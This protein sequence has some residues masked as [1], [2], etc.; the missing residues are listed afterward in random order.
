MV[1]KV[2][3]KDIAEKVG[4][5]IALVSYV[6]NNKKEG[7]IGKDVAEKIRLTAK[8][9]N[10]RPNLIAK[11]LKS[12]R[13]HTIGLIV[14]DIANPFSANLARI[15]ED[16]AE[17]RGYIVIFGSSDEQA[18]KSEKLID[19]FL[20]RQ[21]DGF[22]IAPAAHS[23][24]Q[25]ED[26]LKKEVPLVLIDRYFPALKVSY[27]GIDNY[28]ASLEGVTHLINTGC[29]RIGIITFKTSL[30][31]LKDRK[32]GY[33]AALKKGGIAVSNNWIQE[34]PIEI[35]TQQDIEGAIQQLLHPSVNVDAILFASNKISTF[36]LKYLNTL[37]LKIPQDLSILSFD[38]SD[39]AEVFY[40]PLTHIHQ[41]LQEIGEQAIELLVHSL[42]G[43]KKVTGIQLDATLVLGKST[44]SI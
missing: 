42:N 18:A 26:L 37:K 32:R 29:Q 43:S 31:H 1:K 35:T 3:L 10:Y 6:L 14:A 15:I 2:S 19:V 27:V 7:R 23:E 21:V 16:E 22:I 38:Q 33:K 34:V 40:A 44:R 8:K 9:M 17:K 30:L 13:T 11:S 25:I 4:V 41:P 12:N 5:S 36:G 20:D 39:A 28:K 24:K